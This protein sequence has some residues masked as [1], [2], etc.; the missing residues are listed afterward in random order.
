MRQW[1]ASIAAAS[2]LASVAMALTPKG[3]VRQVTK[4][5]CGLM[6]A[7]AVAG[8]LVQLDF[9]SLAASI[10]AYEKRAEEITS[11]GTEEGK[12]LERTYIEERCA[13]YILGKAT[14]AD[15]VAA[16]GVTVTARW[17]E[18]DLVWYPWEV[19]VNAPYSS[20][21]SAAIEGELGIPGERQSWRGDD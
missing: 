21:L 6:C 20:R 10:A 8:P 16:D 19:T 18:D 17:D 5:T 2:L 13:A 11:Q 9:Q 7:L 1:I 15:K 3:R 14:E 4:L 12:M